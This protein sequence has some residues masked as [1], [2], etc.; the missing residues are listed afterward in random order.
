MVDSRK[1]HIYII[2]VNH[3]SSEESTNG[4]VSARCMMNHNPLY[5]VVRYPF[6][7]NL[8]REMPI[9]V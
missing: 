5:G 8:G 3:H 7:K 4:E 2:R 1:H 9:K 6:N